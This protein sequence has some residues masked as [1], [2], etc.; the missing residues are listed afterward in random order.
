MNQETSDSSSLS[1]NDELGNSTKTILKEKPRKKNRGASIRNWL[2]FERKNRR[3]Q[4]ITR[5]AIVIDEEQTLSMTTGCSCGT[6]FLRALRRIL[7]PDCGC[8][9]IECS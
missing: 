6:R 3:I 9:S 2:N 5:D 4:K 1:S 7:I 8:S